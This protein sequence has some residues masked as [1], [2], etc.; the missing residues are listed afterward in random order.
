MS[1]FFQVLMRS[2]LFEL[3]HGNRGLGT[4]DRFKPGG[5]QG[6]S[7][8]ERRG[9]TPRWVRRKPRL[10]WIPTELKNTVE[11]T[12]LGIGRCRFICKV[13]TKDL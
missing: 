12:K 7:V 6:S 11:V 13:F 4:R 2:S 10:K 9:R 1:K 5:K 8:A 3:V